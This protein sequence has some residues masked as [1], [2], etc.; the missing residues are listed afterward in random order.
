MGNFIDPPASA[1]TIGFNGT[2]A[3]NATKIVEFA[4]TISCT[5]INGD[6]VA[7]KIA[8]LLKP[9]EGYEWHFDN[10][11]MLIKDLQ[12]HGPKDFGLI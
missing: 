8:I 2:I 12:V 4:K 11:T 1:I 5:A 6:D 9:G 7:G 10:L 3:K